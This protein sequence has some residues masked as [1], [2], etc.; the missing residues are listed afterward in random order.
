MMLREK[1]LWMSKNV[2]K[3]KERAYVDQ[4]MAIVVQHN[5]N[6]SCVVKD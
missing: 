2:S 3:K 5:L 6:V 4:G 1:K